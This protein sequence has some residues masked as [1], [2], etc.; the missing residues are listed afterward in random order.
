MGQ[1]HQAFLVA[2]IVPH[3]ETKPRY[4]CVGAYHH[5]W[6]YGTLPLRAVRRFLTLV[7]QKKN[8]EII[9][10]ELRAID[11]QYGRFEQEPDIVAIPC[12]FATSLLGIS[13]TVDLT[14]ESPEVAYVSGRMRMVND[15]LPANVSSWETGT[16]V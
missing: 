11:G 9:R 3:G 4:R 15:I 10:E 13:W 2:R 5:Q 7:K 8:A 12:P 14:A 1:R 16:S 6:C